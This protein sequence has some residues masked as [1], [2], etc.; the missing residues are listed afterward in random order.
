M[1]GLNL[2]LYPAPLTH[3]SRMLKESSA[4]AAFSTF[5]SV[6]LV[7]TDGPG[8]PP[9]EVLD[10]VREIV[11]VPRRVHAG[12]PAE[13]AKGVGLA[14]WAAR[15]LRRYGRQ[16]VACINCHSLPVLPLAVALKLRTG[17]RLV[18]DTH[19]LETE[20]HGLGAARRAVSKLVERTLYRHV[21]ETIVVSDSIADWY[22]DHYRVN[23][24]EVVLNCP[25][26]GRPRR[27]DALRRALAIH[28][29]ATIFLY[30]GILA[31]GRGIE[32]LLDAFAGLR[33]PG[34][35]LVFLGMGSL[36]SLIRAQARLHPNVLFHPAVPPAELARFSAS[37]DVGLC[38]I[39]GT[40]LSYR[41]C[42]PNKLFEYLAAGVPPIVSDLPEIRRAVELHGAGWVLGEWSAAAVR[43]LV[44]GIDSVTVAR[45]R[46]AALRAAEHY[47]WERQ[48]PALQ[49][50][51]GRLGFLKP[52]VA[53]ERLSLP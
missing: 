6:V 10:P 44:A 22:R 12:L 21:D 26:G 30:Q 15:V 33:D 43:D 37:A 48:L 7:G 42:M 3:A 2:H 40:S 23:R 36:E 9:R 14:G 5:D 24:P 20:T 34:K 16:G 8:L 39:E 51:Y 25:P 49:R 52:G 29:D 27:G 18:Y 45:Y 19:E 50:V 28:P 31:P 41:Y 53:H 13:A 46:A 35:V 1:A 4:I 32:L 17:A 47:T 11:R 38:L